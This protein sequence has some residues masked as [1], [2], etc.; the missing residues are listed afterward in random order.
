VLKAHIAPAYGKNHRAHF[1][2]AVERTDPNNKPTPASQ[3]AMPTPLFRQLRPEEFAVAYDILVSATDRNLGFKTI[4]RRT[5]QFSTGLFDM[6][7]MELE[8]P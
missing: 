4:N 6:V 5:V 1:E 8:L 3:G 2:L 7:L